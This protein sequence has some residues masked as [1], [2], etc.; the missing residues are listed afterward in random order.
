MRGDVVLFKAD[1]KDPTDRLISLTTKGPFVHVEIDLG[2]GE[3]IGA[4]FDGIDR[5]KGVPGSNTKSFHPPATPEDIEYAIKW[6]E[7]Q[8]GK[9]YGWTDILS[10]GFKLLG[11][12]LELGEPG[13]WDCSDFAS[14]Y[15]VVARASGPLGRAAE[16]PG[17][18]SPNDIARAY[19]VENE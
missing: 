2:N 16:N 5:Y 1:P 12:P 4:H 10:N 8:V 18:V 11:I 3:L 17:L 6:A 13:H 19:R 15:L 14:R 7:M 9:K